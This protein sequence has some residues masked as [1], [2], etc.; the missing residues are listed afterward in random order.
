MNKISK[1]IIAPPKITQTVTVR[2]KKE[3]KNNHNHLHHPRKHAKGSK[4]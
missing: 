3:D 1:Q 2:G 4:A